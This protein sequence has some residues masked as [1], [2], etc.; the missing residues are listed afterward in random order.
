MKYLLRSS[1]SRAGDNMHRN[2]SKKVISV[3]K[4]KL[5]SELKREQDQCQRPSRRA[6]QAKGTA[7]TKV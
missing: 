1:W 7:K 5:S 2:T 6:F 3:T 4:E